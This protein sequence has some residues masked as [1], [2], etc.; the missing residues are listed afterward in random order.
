MGEAS[1][2]LW[3][4]Q[5]SEIGQSI[6]LF[7]VRPDKK[8][9]E[10]KIKCAQTQFKSVLGHHASYRKKLSK[11]L[12]KGGNLVLQK[13]TKESKLSLGSWL[14]VWEANEICNFLAE[15]ETLKNSKGNYLISKLQI[16]FIM[17][18]K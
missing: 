13:G 1:G 18:A 3:F 6:L 11:K 10:I 12:L 2:K 8:Q 16:S 5:E 9:Q 17:L 4:I 14:V 7:F 15:Y